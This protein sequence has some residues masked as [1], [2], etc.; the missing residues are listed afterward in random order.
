VVVSKGGKEV[1]FIDT[2][3]GKHVTLNS[4]DYELALKDGKNELK[5][6]PVKMTV[7][8][9]E[10]VLATITRGGNPG[11]GL[12]ARPAAGRPPGGPV[13]WWRA[14]GD[15]KDSVGDNHGTLKGGVTFAPGVARQA[16]RLDG[17]TRYVEVPRS[18]L[19]GFGSRDFSIE[20]WVQF[21]ALKPSDN[22]GLPSAAFIACDEGNG[23]QD[24]SRCHK[25][26]FAYGGGYLNFHIV[27]N[28]FGK[29]GHYAKAAFSPDLDRWYHLAVTRSRGTF[30]IYVNGGP[31]AS[32]KV[33]ITIPIP[34]APL[35]IGQ[36]EGDGFFNGLIDEVAI[37]DRA[38]SPAEVKARWSALAPATKPDAEKV[39][40]VRRFVG[41][42]S[43]VWCVALSPD[44]RYALSG[45]YDATRLWDL[46]TGLEIRSYP[47]SVHSV[48][49]FPDGREFLT[50]G[51]PG[52][53]DYWQIETGKQLHSADLHGADPDGALADVAV[54][55]D[56]LLAL[57]AHHDKTLHLWD[58]KNWKEIRR[59][60]G[61]TEWVRRVVFSADGRHALSGAP[62]KTA[63]LWD[64]KTGTQLKCFKG[65]Q[66]HVIGVALSP[67]GRL[68]LSSSFGEMILWDI[69][70]E[71]EL[72]R[73]EGHTGEVCGV[74]FSPD[75]RYALSG[76]GDHSVRLWEVATGKELHR[77]D[78][79]EAMVASVVFSRD[80]RYALSGSHDKTVRLWRLPDLP[81]AKEK[82]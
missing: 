50:C 26:Y 76:G 28:P 37:Y 20:L 2:K 8:R 27:A 29:Y 68:A 67:D 74:A 59:F 1:K 34:D 7:K 18:D 49:F 64:V 63:R 82:P 36:A 69:A 24:R 47:G 14:D 11:D 19:W 71:Q 54:S 6:S 51:N 39:G 48:A 53:I 62:D 60:E 35:T 12:T 38:L 42:T 33:D 23:L 30:T 25:W 10:T 9:G 13:A 31:V 79:H 41:H 46:Q 32:E 3:S 77:F 17:A 5:I 80:G 78:G 58:V 56:G 22:I 52:S 75:G 70:S 45:G 21:R 72:R 61:H 40:E 81:P 16:F 4:G 66:G 15:A 73:F 57:V 44:G 55:P 43:V 65:H